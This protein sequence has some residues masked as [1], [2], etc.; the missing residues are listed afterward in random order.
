M[1]ALFA[2]MC[3]AQGLAHQKVTQPNELRTALEAARGLNQHSVVEVI[4]SREANVAQHRSI[5]EVVRQAVCAAVL[6]RVGM[7]PL[8]A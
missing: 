7:L 6:E 8:A 1:G 2:G 3:R 5:Q 4:T